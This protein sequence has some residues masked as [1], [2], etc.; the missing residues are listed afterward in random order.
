MFEAQDPGNFGRPLLNITKKLRA[1]NLWLKIAVGALSVTAF[2]Y[3]IRSL[4]RKEREY[5]LS[6][7][8]QEDSPTT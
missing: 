2:V 4:K 1:Q 3:Y 7:E 6:N 5:P 8:K